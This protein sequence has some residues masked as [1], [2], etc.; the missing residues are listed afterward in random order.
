[1]RVR[2][3]TSTTQDDAI[4]AG[5]TA[6][7]LSDDTAWGVVQVLSGRA[8]GSENY[9]DLTANSS[10]QNGMFYP[11]LNQVVPTNFDRSFFPVPFRYLKVGEIRYVGGGTVTFFPLDPPDGQK[12][13]DM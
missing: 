3:D 12:R 10:Y 7:L 13:S 1:M 6:L 8:I 4:A 9:N 11:P 2:T 5:T